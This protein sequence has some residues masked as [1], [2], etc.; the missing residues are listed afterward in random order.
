MK[1]FISLFINDITIQK[2]FISLN[3]T[4]NDN[5]G[6]NKFLE[7]KFDFLDYFGILIEIYDQKILDKIMNFFE[8]L[9]RKRH[10]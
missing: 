7:F 9:R 1:K 10:K 2:L 8:K 5:I 6:K 3:D 4:I